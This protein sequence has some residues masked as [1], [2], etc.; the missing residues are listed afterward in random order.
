[1][2]LSFNTLLPI[3]YLFILFSFEVFKHWAFLENLFHI[4]SFNQFLWGIYLCNTLIVVFRF[5]VRIGVISLIFRIRTSL[6]HIKSLLC[7]LKSIL[8]QFKLAL[9]LTKLFLSMSSLA[10]I[11]RLSHELF[12]IQ[13]FLF[14]LL[15]ILDSFL[16]LLFNLYKILI[17]IHR[18]KH[19]N[20]LN[21]TLDGIEG[22]VFV[23]ATNY[24]SIQVWLGIFCFNHVS[25][26]CWDTYR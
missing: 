15:F 22:Q 1:M 13:S 20:S 19:A 2:I 14:S 3:D 5:R 23:D 4:V 6:Y 12:S 26:L 25:G 18:I 16:D 8:S 17:L 7:L 9:S 24:T 21:L 10:R 11:S